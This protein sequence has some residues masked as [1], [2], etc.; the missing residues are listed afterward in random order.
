MS[1]LGLMLASTRR[2][3]EV[4]SE[5][6]LNAGEPYEVLSESE[7]AWGRKINRSD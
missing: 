6:G 5:H 4:Q 3:L 7:S 1:Q 2:L